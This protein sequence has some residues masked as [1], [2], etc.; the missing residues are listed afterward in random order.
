MYIMYVYYS[1]HRNSNAIVQMKQLRTKSKFKYNQD[2]P[3]LF[4]LPRDFRYQNFLLLSTTLFVE[5]WEWFFIISFFFP[6][7]SIKSKRWWKLGIILIIKSSITINE[8]PTLNH[9]I[10]SF[11]RWRK[12]FNSFVQAKLFITIFAV[13]NIT[14]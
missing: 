7:S 14:V 8:F 1:W 13:R 6:T 10:H 9:L 5:M 3:D 12:L 11:Y 4:L 2:F